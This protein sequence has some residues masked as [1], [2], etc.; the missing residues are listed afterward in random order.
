MQK[1]NQVNKRLKSIIADGLDV[2]FNH[3]PVVKTT[4]RDSYTISFFN[5]KFNGEII[6]QY[7]KDNAYHNFRFADKYEPYDKWYRPQ[8]QTAK[9]PEK[10]FS[11][12]QLAS[13]ENIIAGYLDIPKDKLFE[14]EEPTGIR[15][16]L[17]AVDK[18]IGKERLSN[19]DFIQQAMPIV[20][21]R[22]PSYDKVPCLGNSMTLVYTDS[23]ISI[24]GK[25]KWQFESTFH[26][27]YSKIHRFVVTDNPSYSL[28]KH[29][30]E[31][32]FNGTISRWDKKFCS[33]NIL[34]ITPDIELKIITALN[35][36]FTNDKTVWQ[37]LLS[38]DLQYNKVETPIDLSTPIF[39]NI[40][41]L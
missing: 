8:Q 37:E 16:I 6:W 36:K 17:W 24:F 3:C 26:D 12:G 23:A 19:M 21:S 18:R 2:S 4:Y 5:I 1:W 25:S 38:L 27:N 32:D 11:D 10:H 7:P 13:P 28:S 31:I 15:Y 14:Y 20:K 33:K 39:M 40:T 29:A 34:D 41:E 9:T 35:S 30:I 22:I